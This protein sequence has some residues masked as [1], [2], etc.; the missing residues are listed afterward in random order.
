MFMHNCNSMLQTA[1]AE[2]GA[3]T[4]AA[5]LIERD[6]QISALV[7]TSIQGVVVHRDYKPLFANV[8]FAQLAG[9]ATADDVMAFDDILPLLDDD[10]R[11]N[12]KRSWAN[13]AGDAPLLMRRILRRADGTRYHADVLA[14][15]VDWCDQPAILMAV[16]DVSREERALAAETELHNALVRAQKA[17]ARFLAAASHE[18]RTPLHAAMGRLELLLREAAPERVRALAADALAGCRRLLDHVD[19]INDSDCLLSGRLTLAEDA[20]DLDQALIQA[21]ES[22]RQNSDEAS[23]SLQ[24]GLQGGTSRRWGDERRVRRTALALL[25]EAARRTGDGGAVTLTACADPDGLS[26]SIATS[27]PRACVAAADPHPANGFALARAYVARMGGVLIERPSSTAWEAA[28]YIPLPS[29]ADLRLPAPAALDVLVVEDNAGNRRLIRMVLD[30]LGYAVTMAESGEQGVA[31]ALSQRF[32]LVLMD[33]SMPGMDGFAAARAIRAADLP[34]PQPP[35]AAITANTAPGI[36]T[37]VAEAGM[38]A[39]LQKPLELNKLVQTIAL[40]TTARAGSVDAAEIDDVEQE[41]DGD[42]AEDDAKSDHRS[43]LAG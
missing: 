1:P 13:S 31:C 10:A 17:Q 26:L 5:A 40:L 15:S 12:P 11:A 43:V 36:R 27:A 16:L 35:I 37:A 4:L 23:I 7:D 42:E 18:L 41:H 25:E 33:L 14:R 22:A 28:A 39:Y 38:D 20:F 8:R 30:K 6:R 29:M 9:C 2:R 34:W 24:Y 21:V 3:A 32:D 19:D